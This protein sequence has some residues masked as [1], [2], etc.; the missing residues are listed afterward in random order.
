[1]SFAKPSVSALA[2]FMRSSWKTSRPRKSSG[3]TVV[4]TLCESV[5]NHYALKTMTHFPL[6]RSAEASCSRSTTSLPLESEMLLGVPA[7]TPFSST[8]TILLGLNQVLGHGSRSSTEGQVHYTFF[9]P[10]FQMI[11]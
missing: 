6:A 7:I 1:M 11:S 2:R 4:S 5:K 9:I 10:M 3:R 8:G